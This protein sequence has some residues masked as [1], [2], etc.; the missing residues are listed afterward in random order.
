MK[1]FFS[2]SKI[3]EGLG[4]FVWGFC[5][6]MYLIKGDFVFVEI[7]VYWLNLLLLVID[8]DNIMGNLIYII[9]VMSV[10]NYSLR[11][12]NIYCFIVLMF[13]VL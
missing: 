8:I 10:F 6:N 2:N 4:F 9:V 11:E 5:V 13:L 12:E 3:L 1:F 7:V